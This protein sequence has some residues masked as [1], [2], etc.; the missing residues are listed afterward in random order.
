[1]GLRIGI[2]M[3]LP[4]SLPAD[5][6]SDDVWR[7]HAPPVA[8]GNAA[9][10]AADDAWG[11]DGFTFADLLDI[12]NPLQHI[13]VV[14]TLYR[15]MTGDEIAPA[16]QFLGSGLLGGVPGLM[17][18]SLNVA[19]EEAAGQDIGEIVLAAI[20]DDDPAAPA[21][22]TAIAGLSQTPPDKLAMAAQAPAPQTVVAAAGPASFFAAWPP[23][24]AAS[25]DATNPAP[26]A[27]RNTLFRPPAAVK[28]AAIA[29]NLPAAKSPNATPTPAVNAPIDPSL[30]A[31]ANE[32]TTAEAKRIADNR[33]ALLAV[34]RDLRTTIESHEAYKANERL[35][36]LYRAQDGVELQPKQ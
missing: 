25:A 34:A 35:K 9:A 6:T 2:E 3:S 21:P 14:S 11:E 7:P 10:A 20:L 19:V 16:A 18:A 22:S 36:Q 33:A 15:R 13:P 23:N 1:M 28:A 5:L 17:V 4:A 30:T 26:G 24:S 27:I 31:S 32:T 29:A 12:I 8:A